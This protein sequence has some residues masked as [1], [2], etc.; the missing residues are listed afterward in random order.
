MP[1]P[2]EPRQQSLVMPLQA[3]G[4]TID[5]SGVDHFNQEDAGWRISTGLRAA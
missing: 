3:L 2:K 1:G 5:E 4:R